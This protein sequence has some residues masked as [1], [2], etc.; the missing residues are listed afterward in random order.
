MR[1]VLFDLDNTLL[2]G[3]SDFEWGLFLT[4]K[5]VHDPEAY[6]ARNQAFY[7]DY[8]MGRLDID[9][10]LSFQLGPLGN[11]PRTVLDEWHREFMDTRIL[12]KI[13]PGARPLIQKERADNPLMAI[14]TATNSFVTGPIARHL[15]INH[16]VATDPEVGA[17]GEY[18]GKVQ[19]LPCFREGKIDRVEQ[20]LDRQGLKW[21]D[22]DSTVFYS[23][24][25]NDLPLLKK[26]SRPVAVDPDPILLEHANRHGWPV[27]SLRKHP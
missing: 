3:D 14:V 15:E 17:N 11:H 7:D 26:V 8:R 13:N 25:L 23:D 27:I 2:G 19:G 24:S 22:F 4:T 21:K 5:G 6:Q 12:T 10:F 1:L 9:E 18:T 16:L 20:W